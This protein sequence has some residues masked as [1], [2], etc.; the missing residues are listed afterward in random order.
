M[1]GAAQV[2]RA[3]DADVGA[4][5]AALGSAFD[6]DPWIGWIVA[7][8]RHEERITSLQVSL[9]T[10]V[11]LPHGEVWLA[12][13]DGAI[14]GGALWLLADHPVPPGAWAEVAAVEAQLMGEHH[15]RAA[16]AAAATRHL[17]PSTPHHLL[18]TLGV[19]AGARRRGVGAALLAPVL[20]RADEAG[21]DVYLETSTPENLRFYGRHGFEV[22]GHVVVPGGGPPVWALTRRPGAE[23]SGAVRPGIRGA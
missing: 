12:H 3:T 2:R 1:R 9:L 10:A 16:V 14:A 23:P 21:V 7:P 6:G 17:R 20:A 8:D 22:S 5:A 13:H 11:G 18:A 19:V 4:V 15:S